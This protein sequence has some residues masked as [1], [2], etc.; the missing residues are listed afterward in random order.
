MKK[1]HVYLFIKAKLAIFLLFIGLICMNALT[2]QIWLEPQANLDDIKNKLEETGGANIDARNSL[3]Q[4]GVMQAINYGRFG[5]FGRYDAQTNLVKLLVKYGA[6]VN[7]R[8]E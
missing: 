5:E 4:T 1:E 8:S 7:A 3:G 6:D 2:A